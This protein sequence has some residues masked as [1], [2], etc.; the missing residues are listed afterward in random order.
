MAIESLARAVTLSGSVLELAS[1]TPAALWLSACVTNSAWLGSV[2]SIP[3]FL[4]PPS[5]T[6]GPQ[7]AAFRSWPRAIRP[8]AP[9]P[10]IQATYYQRI[11]WIPRGTPQG[12][13]RPL[14]RSSLANRLGARKP[15]QETGASEEADML[16]SVEGWTTDPF[17]SFS[18]FRPAMGG[19]SSRVSSTIEAV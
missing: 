10:G 14:A 19:A 4:T 3:P 1:I 2:Y 11:P 17:R 9:C 13:H 16:H 8:A 18:R 5:C 6:I 15:F 7:P 12:G